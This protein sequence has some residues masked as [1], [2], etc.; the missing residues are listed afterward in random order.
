MKLNKLPSKTHVRK[1]PIDTNVNCNSQN[2]HIVASC[3]RTG[4]MERKESALLTRIDPS[5]FIS[6]HF[7]LTGPKRYLTFYIVVKKCEFT[8]S[9]YVNHE[10]MFPQPRK[11]CVMFVQSEVKI[12]ISWTELQ[13][14]EAVKHVHRQL[15]EIKQSR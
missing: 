9:S 7:N 3:G 10:M 12:Y 2:S 13:I 11:H 8:M 15:Q 5:L 4:G 6:I 1:C 14:P